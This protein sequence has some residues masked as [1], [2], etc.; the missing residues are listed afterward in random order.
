MALI[1]PLAVETAT[2]ILK[3]LQSYTASTS[4]SQ[5]IVLLFVAAA[6][7]FAPSVFKSAGGT[8]YG[9]GTVAAVEGIVPF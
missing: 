8:L 1:S 9:D 7:M 2:A 3:A 6:L 4:V 5:P